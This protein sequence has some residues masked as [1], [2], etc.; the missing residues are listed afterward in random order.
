MKNTTQQS[1]K[2]G[3]DQETI[4]SSVTPD[5]GYHMGKNPIN[6][7]NKSQEVFQQVTTRQQ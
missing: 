6:I 4:Q 3:K 5:Q 1:K 2:D 7:T